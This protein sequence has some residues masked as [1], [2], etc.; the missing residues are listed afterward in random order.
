MLMAAPV[1]V[2]MPNY[3]NEAFLREAID[4]ILSQ[5]FRDFVF[6]IVDDGSTD[7]SIDIINSYTDPRIRLVIKEKN[8]GI[9]DALNKGID[10]VETKYFVRMDGDDLSVPNRIQLLYDFMEAN[11][12]VGVCGSH[13]RLFGDINQVWKMELD[14]ERIKS[15]LIYT[16]SVS[17][18]PSIFRTEVLKKNKIYYTNNHP[19]MED[20]DIFF[21]LKNLTQFAHLDHVLYDYRVLQHNSTVKNKH[22][23]L[24]RKRNMYVQVLSEL[25]IEP[26]ERN[27]DLHVQ[28]FLGDIPLT[29][30]IREYKEWVNTLIRHNEQMKLY[31]QQ[32]FKSFMD[33]T[34][35]GFFFKVVPMSLWK[36]LEYFWVSKKLKYAHVLYLTK[37]KVNKLRG[38]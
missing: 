4:S 30:S 31:P 32:A 14:R 20:Y 2:L 21:R 12:D 36:N 28:L 22:T 11:P 13:L 16:N 25:G 35:N 1:T 29:Y 17:H 6:L 5:T 18:A 24:Q 3:N 9:V 27:I 19:Y 33:K 8:S 7:K 37:V 15:K 10:L 34:W 38:R 23:I 26:S